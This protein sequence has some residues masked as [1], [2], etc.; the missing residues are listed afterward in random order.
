VER[1]E[2][3]LDKIS[4]DIAEIKV[5]LAEQ[6]VILK[7]HTRRSLAG[8]ANLELLREQVKP[9]ESHVM[10]VRGAMKAVVILISL[11]GA[12]ATVIRVLS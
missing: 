8:E 12:I 10:F 4:D 2:I 3:K 6:A 1:I 9:I 11:A 5:T 7:D